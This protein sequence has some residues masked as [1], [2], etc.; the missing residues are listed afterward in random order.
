M[1]ALQNVALLTQSEGA[2]TRTWIT[3]GSSASATLLAARVAT[4]MLHAAMM[5][6]VRLRT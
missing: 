5:V 4:P 1:T 3:V 6:V 2:E